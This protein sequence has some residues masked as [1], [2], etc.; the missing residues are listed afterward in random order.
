MLTRKPGQLSGGQRQRVAV[1]RAIVREPAVFLLDE[2]L[3]NL[4]AKLRVN[5]R[6]EISKLH[7]RLGTT[8]IYVT[9][10]Q[11]EAMTMATRIAVMNEGIIQQVGTPQEL[12]ERPGNIFVAGF[13]GS[14][15]MNLFEVELK[16]DDGR[17]L[18]DSGP[19]QIGVPADRA[20]E[21]ARC[22][23]KHLVLGVRPENIH[24]AAFQPAG[25]S[26]AP[27]TAKVEVTEL[28]GN[29]VFLH[30]TAGDYRFLARVDPRTNA[31]ADQDLS[32]VVDTDRMHVFDPESELA[33]CQDDAGSAPGE[34]GAAAT[35]SEDVAA[36]RAEGNSAR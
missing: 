11:V 10:D 26:A 16:S 15:S 5:T 30:L 19:F 12:Y 6:A 1:A 7:H 13:I 23:R 20:D 33:L 34:S 28:M 25:I 14:P 21:L 32:L 36:S 4:D 17:L 2:P 18:L 8:F 29:E 22:A 27:L 9:H 31:R 3:S 24:D 35:P